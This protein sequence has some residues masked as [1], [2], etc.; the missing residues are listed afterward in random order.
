MEKSDL[1]NQ[2]IDIIFLILSAKN[3]KKH[4]DAQ[5]NTWLKNCPFP[6]FF[7]VGDETAQKTIIKNNTII[8]NCKDTELPKKLLLA[9]KY[10]NNNFSFSHAFACDDDTYVVLDRLVSCG[11]KKY[12]YMGTCYTFEKGTREGLGHA[13]GG[14]G[15]F[16]NKE[17]IERITQIPL[18]HPILEGPSD[19]AIGDLAKMYNIK[20]RSDDR[21]V[22]GYSIKKRHGE[23]PTP[24]NQ[25]ITSHYVDPDLMYKIHVQFKQLNWRNELSKNLKFKQLKAF[26]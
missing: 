2:K 15:F 26:L 10:I 19:T 16:L 24:F 22:Q 8:T 3:N 11:Y 20:L 23:L 14:A 7:I 21:F 17:A 6:Y 18:D 9:Y 13:E 12:M 4:R 25:K 5:K 1:N